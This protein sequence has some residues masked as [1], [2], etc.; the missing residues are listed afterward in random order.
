M[1]REKEKRYKTSELRFCVCVLTIYPKTQQKAL[2]YWITLVSWYLQFPVRKKSPTLMDST[3]QPCLMVTWDIVS[4]LPSC[5]LQQKFPGTPNDY[6]VFYPESFCL[7]FE[8]RFL[9][10]QIIYLFHSNFDH[11]HSKQYSQRKYNFWVRK[12]SV[13]VH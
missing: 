5:L 13:F 4:S 7:H 8:Q 11:D 2:T 10:T 1:T 3:L 9:H 6:K 12:K